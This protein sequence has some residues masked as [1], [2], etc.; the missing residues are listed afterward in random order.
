MYLALV[1]LATLHGLVFMPVAL[2]LVGGGRLAGL[3]GVGPDGI[4]TGFGFGNDA[5]A[6]VRGLGGL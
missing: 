1:I 5:G 6:A 3:Q 2:S 4:G